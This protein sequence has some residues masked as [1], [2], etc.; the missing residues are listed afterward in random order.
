MKLNSGVQVMTR[1]TR[2]LVFVAG[3]ALS[4]AVCL[5]S[6]TLAQDGIDPVA[7]FARTPVHVAVWPPAERSQ[8]ASH[9]SSRSVRPRP[10]ISTRF[11]HP[12][13]RDLVNE[14]FR[15]SR[16]TGASRT[17]A[18]LFKELGVP[19]A[20][21]LDAK[22]SS[23]IGVEEGSTTSNSTHHSSPTA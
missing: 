2:A 20:L 22:T 16:S 4:L 11:C 23:T 18:D 17:S 15:R 1:K 14:A 12:A 8:S 13:V 3:V 9:Y 5:S 19:L 10:S 21:V 6:A 7:G